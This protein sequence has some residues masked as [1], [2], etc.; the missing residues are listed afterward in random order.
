MDK[1][2]PAAKPP[3]EELAEKAAAGSRASFENLMSRYA[4]RLFHF[5]KQRTVSDQDTE[6]LI[7]ETFLKAFRNIDKYNSEWRFSTWLYTIATRSAIS[8]YRSKKPE[9]LTFT[10]KDTASDPQKKILQKEQSQNI[11]NAAKALKHTEYEA[12][13]L[14][15]A[16]EM[17]V[18]EIGKIMKKKPV[19]VRVLLHRAR[20]HLA[21]KIKP[22]ERLEEVTGPATTEHNFSSL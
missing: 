22:S 7:Q 11:W 16:E 13:W 1:I 18:K 9:K 14:F 8:L 10:P 12:L 19:S 3:D 17:T 6:D 21:K 2:S 15:Y 4:P 20:L 5:L